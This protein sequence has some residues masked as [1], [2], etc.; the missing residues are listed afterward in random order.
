[1]RPIS[2]KNWAK[3]VKPDMHVAI[4]GKDTNLQVM[5]TIDVLADLQH[6]RHRIGG[7]EIGRN[8][9]GNLVAD[10]LWNCSRVLFPLVMPLGRSDSPA[11]FSFFGTRNFVNLP[12][13]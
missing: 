13:E 7:S 5:G 6:Q 8:D 1:M 2:A 12:N 4:M 11:Q 10:C 9:F 3:H